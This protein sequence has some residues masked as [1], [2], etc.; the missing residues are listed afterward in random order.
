MNTESF[1]LNNYRV[2]AVVGISAE[3][4]RASNIVARYLQEH[5]FHI[6]P[7]NPGFSSILG[8]KCYP[9]L[10]SIPEKVDVVNI[11]RRSGDVPP[12]VEQAVK[13][14]AKAVWMQEGIIN[15]DSAAF[16]GEAGLLVVMDK[17]I[18]KV[19]HQLNEPD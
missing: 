16:A 18:K 15:V 17:C 11:F 10:L 8:K 6:I 12:I 9:D 7:V 1:I 13:I 19:H 2:I 14:G 5:D 3:D 4:S